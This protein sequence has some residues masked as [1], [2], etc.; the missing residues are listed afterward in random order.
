M[1]YPLVFATSIVPQNT[2]QM[3]DF[4]RFFDDVTANFAIN[5]NL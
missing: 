3:L 1:V 4:M 5:N 2:M